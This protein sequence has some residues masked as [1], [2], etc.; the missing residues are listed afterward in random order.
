[1]ENHLLLFLKDLF[2]L[3]YLPSLGN[4][5][6]FSL[7]FLFG[8]LTS[9]HCIGMCGGI[10][11][12]Q[13]INK[14]EAKTADKKLSKSTFLPI[15][16]YNI[17]RII[18][19]TIIGGIVGGIGQVLTLSGV[20]K[21]IIPIIGGVFM[22]IM[23]INL[24]GIFP[25]LR[26]LNISM[27]KFVAKRIMGKNSSTSPLIV[28]LLTGL[29][30]CGPLQMIQLYALST[31]SAIYGAV[32]AFIF[33]LGTIPG[34]FAFGTF[35]AIINK[36][37]SRYILKFSAVLV[38][39]LGIVMI[40]RGL[41]L[42]GVVFPSFVDSNNKAGDYEVSVIHGNIQIVTTSIGQDYFPPIQVAKGIK[43]R[44]TIK[45][46][47]AVYS[48]CNN[49]IQIPVY[50]IEKKFV[51][52]NNIVE[53][54][55]DKEGEFIYTCWM[56]MIKSKIKVVSREELRRAS[57]SNNL[58]SPIKQ[59]P[60]SSTQT[61]KNTSQ[62]EN[63]SKVSNVKGS[64]AGNSNNELSENNLK[65]SQSKSEDSNTVP[66]QV[67]TPAPAQTT[68]VTLTGF[69]QD[70]DCFVQYVD[71]DTGKAKQDP[72][73]DTKDCLSMQACANS[74]YGMT[75]LRSNGTYKFYYFDGKFATG[76]GESFIPGTG[77]QALAWEL[78]NNTNKQDHITVTVT[79]TLNGDTRTNT[80]ID[81]PANVDE[82]YYPIITVSQL[83][84]N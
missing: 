83:Y 38:I 67:Q 79:G 5:A 54:I 71:S 36:K 80:N 44:W 51:V 59:V 22:I 63:S 45:V 19:Y 82:K 57:N 68:T 28:G 32:S 41:A 4:N 70:E 47:K 72:G 33:T 23:A 49:A 3:K 34:I 31:R 52:G 76:K 40:G 13:C 77:T 16:I 60:N 6:S 55:P 1:M 18:S 50:N 12:T 58:T 26:H 48:D 30:P 39:I 8:I 73:N 7:I 78:I 14:N 21:G 24:L 37:F 35:S 15:T 17:G 20:F 61:S 2:Y 74:G 27:P 69:I 43:V 66:A 42:T 84:E 46:D 65:T 81:F 62:E 9:I 64:T 56:G 29:M 25:V 10:V 11:L 75:A 53:F